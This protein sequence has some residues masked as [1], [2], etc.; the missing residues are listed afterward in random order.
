MTFSNAV[1][2]RD[3]IDEKHSGCDKNM[4][5]YMNVGFRVFHMNKTVVRM[6]HISHC[7]NGPYIVHPESRT[8]H[9]L[10]TRF[11]SRLRRK[12]VAYH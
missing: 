1:S 5:D 2:W 4:C 9:V 3:I 12:A 8:P 7:A 6:D 11:A 10:L